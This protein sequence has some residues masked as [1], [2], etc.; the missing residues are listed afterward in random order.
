MSLPKSKF[1]KG[2][3]FYHSNKNL[4]V[5]IDDVN[6]YDHKGYLYTLKYFTHEVAESKPFKRYYEPKMLTELVSLKANNSM[7]I[8]Y[9]TKSK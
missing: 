8:L 3:V 7:R 6:Y 9:G 4:F 5:V 1:K 2:E